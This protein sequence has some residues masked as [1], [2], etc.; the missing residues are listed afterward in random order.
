[1][2]FYGEGFDHWRGECDPDLQKSF[3]RVGNSDLVLPGVYDSAKTP[4]TQVTLFQSE[5]MGCFYTWSWDQSWRASRQIVVGAL[6]I[7]IF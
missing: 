1:M 2:E 5:K 6:S 3:S 4:S 7:T